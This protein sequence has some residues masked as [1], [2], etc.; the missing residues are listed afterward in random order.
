MSSLIG[1]I[2][3]FRPQELL[4][5]KGRGGEGGGLGVRDSRLVRMARSSSSIREHETAI[6]L[7]A[8]GVAGT[9][10]HITTRTHTLHTCLAYVTRCT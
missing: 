5:L 10:S 8:H 7:R 4:N 3:F 6:A 9:S 2:V 1:A